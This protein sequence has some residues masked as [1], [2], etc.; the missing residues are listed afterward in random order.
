M[1]PPGQ[2]EPARK[3][4]CATVILDEGHS[5]IFSSGETEGE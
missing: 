5:S 4:P 1:T 3:M 2:S